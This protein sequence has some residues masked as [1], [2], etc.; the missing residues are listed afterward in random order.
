MPAMQT[1]DK[2]F[3]TDVA[4][5]W[6]LWLTNNFKRVTPVVSTGKETFGTWFQ[7]F[8]PAKEKGSL[9]TSAYKRL[10]S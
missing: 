8:K 4:I 6:K 3:L 1:T 10:S 7:A 2:K 9:W 5:R